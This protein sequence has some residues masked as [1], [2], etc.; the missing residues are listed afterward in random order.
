MTTEQAAMGA[1]RIVARCRALA[2]LSEVAGAISRPFLCASAKAVQQ[3]VGSWMEAAGLSVRVD[4][5]GNVRGESTSNQA[6]APRLLIGSH[7][8]TV[9]NA[10]AFDGIL[11]VVL[12]IEAA[13]LLRYEALPFVLEVIAFSEEEGVRFGQPFLGSLAVVG[14]AA[15]TLGWTDSDGISVA[16]ALATFGV[17]PA[18][19]TEIAPETAA[20]LEVHIEQGPVLECLDQPL[21]VVDAIAGQSRCTVQ[22][23]GCSNHAGTTPMS[24]RQD[25]LAAAAEWILGVEEHARGC[26]GLVGTVGRIEAHPGGSNIIPGRVT[27]TLD[28]RHAKDGMRTEAAQAMLDRAQAAAARRNVTVTVRLDLDQSAVAMDPLLRAMLA[29]SAAEATGTTAPHLTSGAGHDAMIL[30]QRVPAA[31]LFVRS[32]GGLSHHPGESV[33]PGDVAAAFATVV[34]FLRRYDVKEGAPAMELTHA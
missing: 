25:A 14:R 21:A 20:Y 12:A 18:A 31:M 33:L 28:V 3:H 27:V 11:G 4:G 19:P 32:P 9:S 22:F 30:A 17:N 7:L 13:D 5:M 15:E 24:M 29:R 1:D 6:D 16:Q 26:A 8:D 2:S 34:Q 10:G 23:L